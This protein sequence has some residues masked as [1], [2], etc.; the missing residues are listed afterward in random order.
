MACKSRHLL[1]NVEHLNLHFTEVRPKKTEFSTTLRG[2]F[3][4]N[5]GLIKGPHPSS[6]SSSK[7]RLLMITM[8]TLVVPFWELQVCNRW[9]FSNLVE[10][11]VFLIL[12]IS[13]IISLIIPYLEKRSWFPYT[14]GLFVDD[15]GLT[16]S[17]HQE[18]YESFMIIELY[19]PL[20]RSITM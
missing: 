14:N 6:S 12:I 15:N 7:F 9:I 18:W 17:W 4:L 19:I 8:V 5:T 2:K 10:T 1:N 3:C 20:L 16:C 13:I 11:R